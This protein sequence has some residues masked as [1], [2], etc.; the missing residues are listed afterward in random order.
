MPLR[1]MIDT[2]VAFD[3]WMAVLFL[4]Q[5]P[6]VDVCALTVAATGEAHA[7]PGMQTLLRLLALTTHPDIPVAAGR[8]KPLTGTHTFPLLLRLVM[9]VRFGL[10]LP[11]ARKRPVKETAVQ[12]LARQLRANDEQTTIVALGPLT[13]LA[14]LL[15]VEPSLGAKIA[16]IYIMGGA[17][18]V[19]GNIPEVNARIKNPYAEWNVFVDPYALDVL[20]RSGVPLTL[21]PLDV[22][23]QYQLTPAFIKRLG[24]HQSTPAAE[25]LYRALRRLARVVGARPYYF[26]DPLTAVVAACPE[27]ATFRDECI[28]VIQEEGQQ[29]GRTI[30]DPVGYPVRV[31]VTVDPAAFEDLFL[32]EVNHTRE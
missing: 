6:L 23:N 9:D 21:V 24:Q 17:L 30:I 11:K 27:L 29:S 5:S 3:D 8:R 20:L 16:M 22:T 18:D 19:P 25:F 2:D 14:E 4:L 1:L 26:W 12:L 28:R 31:C 13:N 7:R 10:K 32:S 15:L